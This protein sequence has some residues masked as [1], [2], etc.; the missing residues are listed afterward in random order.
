MAFTDLKSLLVGQKTWDIK[1]GLRAQQE[2][3]IA[4]CAPALASTEDRG[5]A[6]WRI[7]QV[8]DW[9]NL[10]NFSWCTVSVH[11][12][13]YQQCLGRLHQWWTAVAGCHP[14]IRNQRNLVHFRSDINLQVSLQRPPS[15]SRTLSNARRDAAQEENPTAVA[16]SSQPKILFLFSF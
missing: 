11:L 6:T 12:V 7:P 10:Q 16:T 13:S 1:E 5:S 4:P 9:S 14:R 15:A 2:Q 3:V 8:A